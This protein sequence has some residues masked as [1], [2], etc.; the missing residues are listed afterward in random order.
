MGGYTQVDMIEVIGSGMDDGR[1]WQPC[2]R[3]RKSGER[4]GKAQTRVSGD[5]MTG[6]RRRVAILAMT[7][8]TVKGCCDLRE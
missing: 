6:D 1:N 5:W 2:E 8:T 4:E 3:E 7:M